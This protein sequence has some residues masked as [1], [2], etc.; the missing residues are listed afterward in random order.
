MKTVLRGGYMRRRIS[1]VLRLA[2]PGLCAISLGACFHPSAQ[3]AVAPTGNYGGTVVAYP[4]G[5]YGYDPYPG[6]YSYGYGYAPYGYGY[7]GYGY[8]APRVIVRPRIYRRRS[9]G[10]GS[11]S[12]RGS[13]Q[14]GLHPWNQRHRVGRL[15]P[16]EGRG[17]LPS[18]RPPVTGRMAHPRPPLPAPVT[19]RPA[20]AVVPKPSAPTRRTAVPRP[21]QRPPERPAPR[22]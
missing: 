8:V 11:G 16:P 4:V 2:G 5:G 13:G 10:S 3:E 21:S 1:N 18:A 17:P 7:P 19:P 20:P 22:H 14:Y 15:T 12:N 9:F 6:Y